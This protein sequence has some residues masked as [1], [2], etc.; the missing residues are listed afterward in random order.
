MLT[1]SR[2]MIATPP[3]A[4][5]KEQ[6]AD[7]CMSQKELAL[8]MD[9]SEKH[10][11]HLINGSVQ[12]TSDVAM[13]LEIVL[14]VPARFWNNLEAIYREKL[15]KIKNENEMDADI[16]IA[17]K[18]PYNEMAKNGWVRETKDKKERVENLRKYFELVNLEKIQSSIVA[19]I[20]C[21]RLKETK[22]SDYALIAWAQKAKIEAKKQSVNPINRE[23]LIKEIPSIRKMTTAA[24]SVFQKE[25]NKTLADCGVVLILL[26]HIGGSFLHGATFYSGKKIVLGM[27]VRGKD[28][29][30]FWFSFFHEL[31]HIILGHIDQIDGTTEED[32]KNADEFAKNTLIEPIDFEK[33]VNEK[34][35][36]KNAIHAF[37]RKI[38]IDEGIIVGRLQKE[39]YIQFTEYNEFKTKYEIVE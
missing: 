35:F 24:P 15:T 19:N 17:R 23:R 32:E 5:I 1:K 10:I 2:T 25:L 7:R 16:L 36:D 12:L 38:Q 3:G 21:R 27:T 4:T 20:A 14:G 8:R 9:M 33:F 22:S 28:A 37:A 6:L 26:P 31:G 39:K 18:L 13:R 29:D 30:R 11:S 34:K